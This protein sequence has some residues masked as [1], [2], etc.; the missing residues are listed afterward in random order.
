MTRL[1]LLAP[2]LAVIFGLLFVPSPPVINWAQNVDPWVLQTSEQGSTEFLIFLNEQA[3][4]SQAAFLPTKLEKGV[5]VYEQLTS[6]AAR[7]QPALLR[8][9][10]WLA[11]NRASVVAFR[12]YWVANMIWVRADRAVLQEMAVRSE[13]AH[14]Y[15][16]PAVKLDAPLPEP[17]KVTPSPLATGEGT[18]W[19]L[20][21]VGA[22]QVWALGYNGQGVV[23]GGQDTGYAWQHP[24]LKEKYR[25]WN[26]STAD[27]NYSWHDA[28]HSGTGTCSH[29]IPYPCDDFGHGT[30]T[31][32]IMVG[33]DSQGNRIG[34]AP[35]ARWIG[36]RNMRNGFGTP[37]TYSECYQWFI[38]PTDLNGQNPRPDLAPD[39][40]NNSWSC[41]PSEGCNDPNILKTV[42]ENV[43]AAGIVSVHAAGN[44]GPACSTISTPAAIYAA[45]FTVGNSDQ[46]DIIHSSSS[47]GAVTVDGS[48]R[49]K[50]NVTAPG[51]NIRSSLPP[52][53]YGTSIGTSMAAPHVAGL[54]ALLIS[55]EPE[56][57]GQ[58][59]TIETII[60]Q[61][62]LP[63]TTTQLC[64]GVP[65]NRIP[66][67]TYGY[68]RIRALESVGV[69]RRLTLHK[70]PSSWFFAPNEVI[71]YT[72]QVTNTSPLAT[73]TNVQ[74]QDTL[75]M[76][77]S[78]LSANPSGTCDEG[79]CTWFFP[80]LA[81]GEGRT[82]H[83]VVQA[84]PEM[85]ENIVNQDYAAQSDQTS[86]IT[87]SPVVVVYLPQP[88]I[89]SLFLPLIRR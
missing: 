69:L 39:V 36:C 9:L 27:H 60:E 72:L 50:P 83:F 30:H 4:L 51:T 57:R 85:R 21:K 3:D 35:G 82:V 26:G 48:N 64:N 84:N 33:D 73:L 20:L 5:Y 43:V 74:L 40:I 23:I 25:G 67:N 13:V 86:P 47:R 42:V 65:G 68:G 76:G 66:N 45:S 11:A 29:D 88:V 37:A 24:A 12:P 10:E 31:M 1:T 15:A 70:Q 16:N 18:E 58:V 54:V 38:A 14:I 53:D 75:P 79:V 6:T 78:F 41:P 28:I 89:H 61:N 17:D 81:A 59:D 62:A 52:N 56:L 8:R 22:P 2:F 77:T 46:N 49:L 71:T 55:A 80:S 32:G 7:T 34:M 44:S 87:G 63:I 19:N